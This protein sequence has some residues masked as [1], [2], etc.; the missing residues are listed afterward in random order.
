MYGNAE[1]IIETGDTVK[2]VLVLNGDELVVEKGDNRAR[3]RM[4]GIHSF[5]PVVNEREITAFGDASVRFLRHWILNHNVR[6]VF[7][8]P[9]QDSHGRY[10]AYIFSGDMDINR[11]MVSEGLSMVYTEFPTQKERDYLNA[12][13]T[14]RAKG[15]GLWGGHKART[16][17][18]GLRRGW[19]KKRR[20]RDGVHNLD[21]LLE[22]ER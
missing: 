10:L 17:I 8:A 5:D 19:S 22:E 12:E 21:P 3:V 11:R 6:M 14:P 16:R 15:V 7:D 2:V 4:L 18:I 13:M 20:L 1:A 9:I